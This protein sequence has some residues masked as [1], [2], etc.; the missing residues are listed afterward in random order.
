M[1]QAQPMEV[2]PTEIKRKTYF[3]FKF[4]L[5][6][7]EYEGKGS[8]LAENCYVD[9]GRVKKLKGQELWKDTSTPAEIVWMGAY[10]K[11]DGTFQ[12]LYA[13]LSGAIYL[14]KAVEHD[15]LSIVTPSGGAGDVNFTSDNFDITQIG[16]TAYISNESAT[17]PMY[18]WDGA[19]LTAIT[20]APASPKYLLRDGNR[21]ATNKE[22]SDEAPADWTGGAGSTASGDYAMSIEP[23]GGVEAG[24]GIIVFGKMGAE[25]HK[26]IPNNASDGVSAK[27]KIDGFSYTG[28]GIQNTHQCV[29]GKNF[30]YFLNKDG[31]HEMNPYDGT[32]VN[33]TDSGN[34]SRRWK[35]YTLTNAFIDYDSEN[36]R[37]IAV[38]KK[39][40]QNDT[41]IVIDTKWKERPIS[42]QTGAYF[43]SSANVNNQMYGGSSHDS[44]ILKIFETYTNRDV[45]ALQFRYIIEWDAITNAM[46][47]KRLKRFAIFANLNPNSSFTA[48]LYKD[49]SQEAIKEQT[50]TTSSSIESGTLGTTIAP[51]G[52]YIFNLGGGRDTASADTNSDKIERVR[53]NTKCSIF[54]LEIVEESFYDFTLNDVMIEFKT[55]GRLIPS[56]SIPNSLF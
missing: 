22:F 40:G 47:E 26:V 35:T 23:V 44:K 7:S 50:F 17:T 34:I 10:E 56:K 45:T 5:R 27:T 11:S 28:A 9:D 6:S 1:T 55:K 16:T 53:K 24:A 48:K 38:V 37:V 39:R 20:N 32:T 8:A 49:G 54:T 4:M 21:L 46:L 29:A 30:V 15:D 33:L 43:S 14:L 18:S 36:D 51:W 25:S 52:K 3:P 19:T 13:Y 31:I 42:I 12:T 2:K 41:L